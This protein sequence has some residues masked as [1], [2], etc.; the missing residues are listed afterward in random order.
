MQVTVPQLKHH[1]RHTHRDHLLPGQP[2]SRQRKNPF[3]IL[4]MERKQKPT[5]F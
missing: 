3:L 5:G 4:L 2:F 1:I